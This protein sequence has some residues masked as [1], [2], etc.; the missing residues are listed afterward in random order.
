[1]NLA[2]V[3]TVVAALE[4]PPTAPVPAWVEPVEVPTSSAADGASRLLLH[5]VQ[6]RLGKDEE[7]F[8]RLAWKVL[9]Q[10]GV[11]S[12][13]R[14]EF[15]WDPSWEQ[16][17]LH[18]VWIWRDGERRVAWDKEDARVIQRESSL[19]EGM[20]DG[21]LT[22]IIELRDLREGDVVE[23]ASSTRGQ[24]PVFKG[25]FSSRHYQ[26]WDEGL[27]R[28]HFRLVWERPRALHFAVHGGAQAPAVTTEQG[29]QV[30][31]WN[32]T[33]LPT[34]NLEPSM[35]LDLE[36]A[37]FVE[38]T[39][40]EDWGDVAR[41]AEGLFVLPSEGKR[42]AAELQRFN[43]MPEGDRGRAIV[44]FVQDDV[45]YVG[46]EIGEHSHLPHPPAWV[47]ER[48]FGDCK[49]KSL[50][51]VAL[52]RAAGLQ[53]WPALVNSSRGAML[54][55]LSPSPHA[56]NHAIVQVLLPSG[57]RFIDPTMTL[58]RGA[59]EKMSQP[60]YHHALVIKP[61]VTALEPIPTDPVEG[62]TWEVEQHWE[63][64]SLTGKAKLTVTTTARG[65]EASTLRRQVK[66]KTQ[67]ALTREQ[68]RARE[69]DLEWKLTPVQVTWTDDEG[70]ELFVLKEQYEAATFY[71]EDDSHRFRT[72]VMQNDLKR[73]NE[74]ER[75]W[76][77]A[78]WYPL[79][80]KEVILYDSPEDLDATDFELV[81]RDITHPT[82]RMRVA[83]AVTKRQLKLEWELETLAD[84]VLPSEVES[85]RKQSS[86][87]WDELA[88]RVFAPVA[89]STPAA[90]SIG[91][92]SALM[93]WGLVGA[94]VGV[95]TV[96][97]LLVRSTS[98]EAVAKRNAR[99]QQFRAKQ[100]G[101]PGELAS[102][103]ALVKSLEAGIKLFTS[104][105]CP[106]GHGWDV[107]NESDTVRLGEEK[108]TVLSRKCRTCHAR[109][110]RYVKL[111]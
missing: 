70:D 15:E 45:R 100:V 52:F 59:L 14:Q 73:L 105:G 93:A 9:S 69:D 96:L 46:V 92:P 37:P 51:L 22:L 31:R 42:F 111:T 32:L 77:F 56:F 58:R 54:P 87:A 97:L 86:E 8:D 34:V 99:T 41:W 5:D 55:K 57:P 104:L 26:S 79:R 23:V 4:L 88:Y 80:V 66:S 61:G 71:E 67:E 47:L 68:R 28:S 72:L 75:R 76:P 39:D 81:N 53:A 103:P 107:V 25:R 27:E 49:D 85:Y 108:V 17:Q 48:G 95:M 20:Y 19:A 6:L 90:V 33:K 24:N 44:R 110:D 78:L 30:Y 63:V 13:S 109:E 16:L 106:N 64:P 65:R 74:Q 2:L 83:Q 43:S 62:P 38:F 94:L 102:S 29:A 40:W 50:L 18:G 82:F 7:R 21:R 1:M 84:R 91:E 3:L 36:P 11:E 98:P 10:T 35:P 60:R 12:L 101:A 89:K